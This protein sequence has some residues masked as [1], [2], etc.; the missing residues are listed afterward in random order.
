MCWKMFWEGARA[1]AQPWCVQLAPYGPLDPHWDTAVLSARLCLSL[2]HMSLSVLGTEGTAQHGSVPQGE[3]HF[4]LQHS[5]TVLSTFGM[6]S[7]VTG[8]LQP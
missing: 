7:E 8:N 5:Y 3:S 6:V 1:S 2:F 4:S